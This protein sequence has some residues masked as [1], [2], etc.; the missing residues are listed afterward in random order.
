MNLR[1]RQCTFNDV[2]LA[3]FE[4][5]EGRIDARYAQTD[6]IFRESG[7]YDNRKELQTARVQMDTKR[8]M[9]IEF[10]DAKV[11]PFGFHDAGNAMWNGLKTREISLTDGVYKVSIICVHSCHCHANYCDLI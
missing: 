9:F 4:R 3:V 11:V 10:F 6:R 5:L 8:G 1:K 2:D 7:H